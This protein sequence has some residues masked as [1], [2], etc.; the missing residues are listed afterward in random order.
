M[1]EIQKN[2]AQLPNITKETVMNYL[3]F[4]G[5]AQNLNDNELSMFIEISKQFQLN[6]FK[7]EIYVSKYGS[8]FSIIVGYEVYIKRA[9]RS[10]LLDGWKVETFG[11]V[12]DLTARV[13]IVRKDR[14]L[15]FVHDVHYSEYVQTTKEGNPNKFWREKPMTMLKKVAISQGFRMCFSDEL[16]G[17]PY[18]ADEILNEQQLEP[19]EKVVSKETEQLREDFTTL[20][21]HDALLKFRDKIYPKINT[22][23]DL[24]LIRGID[25]GTNLIEEYRKVGVNGEDNG[26]IE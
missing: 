5:H 4:A 17:M 8:N 11:K 6:P 19:F 13:T 26:H 14:K 25:W 16:G 24:D 22:M 9:E 3:R 10:G 20:L 18:T 2:E 7:R 23:S 12:P 1:S 15:D 21:D